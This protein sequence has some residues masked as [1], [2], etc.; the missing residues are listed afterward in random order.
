[1]LTSSPQSPE[2][3]LSKQ[4]AALVNAKQLAAV[5]RQLDLGAHLRLGRGEERQGGR[6]KPS[7]LAD[8]CEAVLGAVFLDGGLPA[9]RRFVKR[10][11]GPQLKALGTHGWR[12][13]KTGLQEFTQAR[14]KLS[15]A[16]LLVETSGPS[17]GRHFRV[18]CRLGRW[19]LA[20]GEGRTK[21]Q[22]G[23]AA[24]AQARQLFPEIPA[25]APDTEDT[26]PMEFIP[27]G[28]STS[29]LQ[30]VRSLALVGG[31]AGKVDAAWEKFSQNLTARGCEVYLL[32]PGQPQE[33]P[34]GGLRSLLDLPERVDLVMITA[35][36]GAR[37]FWLE[38]VLIVQ[39][40]LLWVAGDLGGDEVRAS[41]S[42]RGIRLLGRA[43]KD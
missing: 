43:E 41:L 5:A 18:E 32:E 4:R 3:E 19:P 31:P 12:D 2:G 30:D 22:A 23:Q 34:Q 21:K 27:A 24:A 9:A 6:G 14:F 33:G 42:R 40:R 36:S 35:A 1:M 38:E 7:I 8:T 11:L 26:P 17:H 15:P 39:P 16:Y 37:G 29:W 25:E 10:W 20:Q 13:D 28:E